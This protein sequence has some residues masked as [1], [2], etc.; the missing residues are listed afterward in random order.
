MLVESGDVHKI[1]QLI[2]WILEEITFANSFWNCL[3]WCSF[4]CFSSYLIH[5]LFEYYFFTIENKLKQEDDEG[6][7][8]TLQ[9]SMSAITADPVYGLQASKPSDFVIFINLVDF[10]R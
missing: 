3:H 2:V 1:D 6:A 8:D 4:S 10:C 9:E 7:S 5:I